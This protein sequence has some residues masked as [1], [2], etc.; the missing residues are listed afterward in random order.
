MHSSRVRQSA[1]RDRSYLCHMGA[2]LFCDDYKFAEPYVSERLVTR[3]GFMSGFL[4]RGGAE[5]S[6]RLAAPQ[7]FLD[8]WQQSPPQQKCM[9]KRDV[10][11]PR[12]FLLF[13]VSL[14]QA[15]HKYLASRKC[16]QKR[17]VKIPRRFPLFSVSLT[18]AL[19]KHLASGNQTGDL[20][21]Y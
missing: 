2:L 12:G 11:V 7:I 19:Y 15:L 18:Q 17:G 3:S 13:Y 8:C 14:T 6:R 9:Q 1:L 20:E 10:K 16:T 4:P 5:L 21:L